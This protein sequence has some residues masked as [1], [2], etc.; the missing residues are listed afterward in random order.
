M[1]LLSLL[2]SLTANAQDC[3]A[4]P[5]ALKDAAPREAS[6]MFVELSECN[7]PTAKKMADATLKGLL[8]DEDG[9]KAAMAAIGVGAHD[10]ART[11]ISGL[12]SDDHAPMIRVLGKA[13]GKDE[14]IQGFL[15]GSAEALGADFWSKRW[16]RAFVDCRVPAIQK[17]L[18]AHVETGGGGDDQTAYFGVVSAW[19]S[20]VSAEA[21][22]KLEKMVAE[23]EDTDTRV[24][25]IQAFTDAAQVGTPGGTDA[26]IAEAGAAA[27]KRLSVSLPAKAVD[28]ARN[29][30]MALGDEEGADALVKVRYNGVIQE[31]DYLLYGVVVVETAT[32]KNG[33]VQQFV[34]EAELTDP[35]QTWPDQLEGKVKSVIEHHWKLNLAERCKG[36]GK[37]EFKLPFKPF[38]DKAAYKA[39]VAEQIKGVKHPDVKKPIHKNH[40]LIEL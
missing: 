2:L 16:Y 26:K 6:R 11:W 14:A 23:S 33:K 32:C 5:K 28:Q 36:E 34:H 40:S 37:T 25:L 29:T 38:G 13:C 21:V 8:G 15:A 10:A 35:G 22:P 1:V 9:Q 18:T 24:M 17:I 20:N 3:K 30:L 4:I 27:I 7:A 31:G 39:W 19:A 12:Q